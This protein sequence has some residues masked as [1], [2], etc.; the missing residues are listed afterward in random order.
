MTQTTLA[1]VGGYTARERNGR[2]EGVNVYRVDPGSGAWSHLQLLP[3]IANPSWLTL[4]RPGRFLY[5]AHG[6][7]T[8]ATAYAIDP[9]SGRLR[10][11]G[12]Q[13]TGGTN[14]VRLG[15]DA[16]DRFL[17]CA[18]YSSGTVA[19]LPIET[20]GSLGALRDLVPLDGTPGPH[21]TQQTSAHP[22]DIAFDPRGRFFLVPDKGLDAVF[23][24]RV[25]TAGGKLVAG[26][27]PRVAARAGA[28]PRHAVF[29]PTGPY[30][31]MLNELD[32]TL[33][34]YRFDAERGGLSPLQ[35]ITTLPPDF[36][37]NN[38]TS[39]IAIAPSGRFV[40]GSNRG[41][42]SIAIFRVDESTGTLHPVGWEPTQGKT[43][44]FIAL[45]PAGAF[46]YAANQDSDT[47]VAFRTDP[48]AGTLTPTGQI[49]RVG[50]PSSIVFR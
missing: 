12:R 37:G 14:G 41:H 29:H 46:L 45:D 44:R 9:A 11:L 3:D 49:V 33:T 48:R 8:E 13:P 32:S 7:G 38:T 19:V 39:E 27:P 17:V 31:Y 4:D 34:T 20:D 36:T 50:S 26:T 42:D 18:N 15:I 10:V 16:S 40:Y 2:G 24:F 23:V 28:G 1:Y 21:R 47:I 30:A 22:H 43:P 35:V 25:D 5:A 6:D